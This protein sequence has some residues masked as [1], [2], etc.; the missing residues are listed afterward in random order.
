MTIQHASISDPYVHEPKGVS[1]AASGSVYVSNGAGSGT[2]KR[3][4][5][6]AIAGLSGDGGS[7][8]LRPVSNGTNGFNLKTDSAY[9]VMEIVNNTNAFVVSAAVDTTL[10]TNTDYALFTGTGAPWAAGLLFGVTYS[11]NQLVAPVAGVYRIEYWANISQFPTATAKV[12]VKH[13]TNGT[14]FS[15]KHPMTSASATTDARNLAGFSLL[16][17]SAGDYVQP[18]IASTGAGNIILSDFHLSLQ[19]VRAS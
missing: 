9:G 10:N 19:L 13:R 6:T 8:N 14:T 16:S 15:S 4:D 2:W 7:T 11:S 1:V 12:S 18:Y 3:I 5:S 17:L